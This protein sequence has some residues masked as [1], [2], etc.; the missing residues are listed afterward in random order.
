ME[1]QGVFDTETKPGVDKA[2]KTAD[3]KPFDAKREGISEGDK[4]K[5]TANKIMKVLDYLKKASE[6]VE[7]ASAYVPTIA[8]GAKQS[9]DRL[10]QARQ[11]VTAAMGDMRVNL[12]KMVDKDPSLQDVVSKWLDGEGS[13]QMSKDDIV[14]KPAEEPAEDMAPSSEAPE[15]PEPP[16]VQASPESNMSK[17]TE[18][19]PEPPADELKPKASANEAFLKKLD[20]AIIED[21]VAK[22][23]R[24]TSKPKKLVWQ[25]EKA[26]TKSSWMTRGVTGHGYGSGGKFNDH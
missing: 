17:D 23:R 13:G 7:T 3:L 2:P 9:M 25:P 22:E 15:A 6:L 24:Q 1:Q 11:Y 5:D 8:G 10:Y 19:L 16:K 20:K 26:G 14:L 21:G 4:N 12:I 18:K